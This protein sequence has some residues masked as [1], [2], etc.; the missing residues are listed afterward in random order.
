MYRAAGKP[1]TAKRRWRGTIP[2]GSIRSSDHPKTIYTY[3]EGVRWKGKQKRERR[4]ECG[5]YIKY[6]VISRAS[7]IFEGRPLVWY[8]Q[9]IDF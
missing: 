4:S 5:Q 8:P 2:L 3:R 1:A 6:R 9:D 7:T